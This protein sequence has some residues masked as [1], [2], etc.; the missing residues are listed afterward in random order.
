MA[1][2][3][4]RAK[5]ASKGAPIVA[6]VKPSQGGSGLRWVAGPST[7]MP[8]RVCSDLLPSTFPG[9]PASGNASQHEEAVENNK[10]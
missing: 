10:V 7:G 4:R 1:A 3:A 8:A 2:A 9:F 6:E 5:V